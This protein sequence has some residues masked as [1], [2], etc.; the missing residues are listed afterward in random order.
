MEKEYR[1]TNGNLI[2][3]DKGIVIIRGLKGFFLG[4]GMIRGNKSI[5]YESIAAVQFKEVGLTAGYI[6]FTLIGGSE[7]KGGLLQ[8]VRDENSI[9]FNTKRTSAKF[10]EAKSLVEERIHARSN[11]QRKNEGADDLEKYAELRDK[12]VLTE[13]EFQ[14]KKRKILEL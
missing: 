2:L 11:L 9:S 3:S 14:A 4:G 5:P 1:G 13:D 8:A 6:Q 7:A 10:T 12:G